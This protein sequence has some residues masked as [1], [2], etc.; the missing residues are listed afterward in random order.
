MEALS[1]L[2]E[3]VPVIP[4]I[5]VTVGPWVCLLWLVWCVAA[6]GLCLHPKYARRTRLLL[7]GIAAFLRKRRFF[8]LHRFALLILE[9]V[10][11]L[12]AMLGIIPPLSKNAR[13][14]VEAVL[15]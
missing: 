1:I 8:S 13:K 12:A 5:L 11:V 3:F 15:R 14:L 4:S 6:A 9:T 2:T 7:A 10:V